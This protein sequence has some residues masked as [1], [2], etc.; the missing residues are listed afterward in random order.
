M[1]SYFFLSHSPGNLL[2]A[3]FTSFEPFTPTLWEKEK[4]SVGMPHL[5]LS[6]MSTYLH[7]FLSY[8]CFFWPQNIPSSLEPILCHFLRTPTHNNPFLLHRGF[9]VHS[10]ALT[11]SLVPGVTEVYEACLKLIV[12]HISFILSTLIE[13]KLIYHT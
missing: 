6:I 5:P 7:L 8:F 4:P 3:V 2:W 10:A 12:W 11:F 13:Y 9:S 1:H